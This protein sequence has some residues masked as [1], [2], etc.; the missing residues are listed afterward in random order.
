MVVSHHPKLTSSELS[1]LWSTYMSD[2]MAV[3]VMKHFIRNTDDVNVKDIIMQAKSYSEEHLQ[4]IKELFKKE[5]I[6][7]PQGFT[8][9]D[10]NE[11][12]PRLFSDE[13]YLRYLRQMGRSGMATYSLATGTSVR[14]D[15]LTS[16][17]A[18]L[19]ESS[20]L[21]KDT[22]DLMV[23]KGIIVR[24]PVIPYPLEVEFVEKQHFLAGFFGE[25]RPLL[26]LE[27][28]HLGTNIEINDNLMTLFLGF[29]QVA[30]NKEV[31]HYLV[32]G[33]EIMTKQKEVFTS[34]LE[35][36]N[37]PIPGTWDANMTASTTSPF[38]DKLIM[39]HIGALLAMSF[40]DYGTAIGAS[41]RSDLA[42]NYTRL[43]AEIGKFAEDGT[44]I[45]I[46][47]HWMEKPPQTLNRDQLV[48]HT[49]S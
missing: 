8:D 12:A 30:H 13:F 17:K 25:K 23:K 28:A 9:A 32:R 46:K 39:F 47:Y 38:S 1:M 6:P 20:T 24:S 40:G 41:F 11:T 14:G 27:V 18:W 26:A 5:Q 34:I 22:T 33:H 42:V 3:F 15:V 29:A 4:S 44:N 10:F 36:N 43:M 16:F 7:V 48:K 31:S 19:S 49:K 45:M 35:L 21:Y 2:S 37:S